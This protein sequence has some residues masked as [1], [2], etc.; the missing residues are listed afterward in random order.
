MFQW[1]HS[2]F[3]HLPHFGNVIIFITTFLNSIGI[4]LPGEPILFGAGFILGRT[5]HPLWAAIAAGTTACFLGGETAFWLGRRLG[6]GRLQKIHWLHLTPKN[7]GKMDHFFKRYGAKT[8]FIARFIALLPPLVP[9][10][11]AGMSKMKWRVFL[12][13]NLS[14]AVVYVALYILLGYFLGTHWEFLKDSLGPA[15]IYFIFQG[16]LLIVLVVIFRHF[17]YRFWKKHFG[18]RKRK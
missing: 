11:L 2:L 14:G 1:L 8:V 10:V 9:N 7:F 18:K 15:A 13:Y 12:F 5:G 17:L 3:P 16:V 4:P 6:R